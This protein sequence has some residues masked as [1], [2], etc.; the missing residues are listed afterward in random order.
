MFEINMR[1]GPTALIAVVVFATAILAL[2]SAQAQTY[3][4]LHSFSDRGDGGFPYAGVNLI[5]G[6]LY[7]TT[8]EGGRYGY[9]TVYELKHRG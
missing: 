8:S 1:A 2:P 4:V 6:S 7:G 9:G 3:T 5:V